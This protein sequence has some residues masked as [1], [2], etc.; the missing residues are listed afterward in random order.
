LSPRARSIEKRVLLVLDNLEQVLD[1]APV[2]GDVLGACLRMQVLTT[3]REP[4]G[5]DG[6]HHFPVSSLAR[7]DPRQL[8]AVEQLREFDAVHLFVDRAR[9]DG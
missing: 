4:L 6:E 7:P 9:G 3:S 8:P 5:I 2:I 1:A